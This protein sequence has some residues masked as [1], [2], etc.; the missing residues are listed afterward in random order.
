M[1][2]DD[3][4]IH[5]LFYHNTNNLFESHSRKNRIKPCPGTFGTSLLRKVP[6]EQRTGNDWL[7]P[8]KVQWQIPDE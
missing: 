3:L 4:F 7:S 8:T 2:V 1:F 6:T 5:V